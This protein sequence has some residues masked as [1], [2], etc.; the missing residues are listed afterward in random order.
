MGNKDAIT[1]HEIRITLRI[2]KLSVLNWPNKHFG[3]KSKHLIIH[4]IKRTNFV[5]TLLLINIFMLSGFALTSSERKYYRNLI[6]NMIILF[7][8]TY[9]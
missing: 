9:C 3:G 2:Q 7:L 4:K 5:F 6:S 8:M 1:H